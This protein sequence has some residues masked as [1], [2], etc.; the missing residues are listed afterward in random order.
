VGVVDPIGDPAVRD[1]RD[2]RQECQDI[3][4]FDAWAPVYE[5]SAL[6]EVFYARLHR[7]VLGLA[8]GAGSAPGRIVDVGCGTGRLLRT[9]A[10][11]FPDARLVGVDISA[12]MLAQAQ[13]M[14]APGERGV[15]VRADS[16]ALPFA[17]AAFDVATCTACSHHWPEP[18]AALGE[19]RRVVAADGLLVL[20]H[21]QGIALWDP[22]RA[23][24]IRRR[25]VRISSGLAVPLFDSG[26]RVSDAALFAECP[27]MP[28]TVVLCAR[29]R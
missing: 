2:V 1:L 14:T 11:A 29:R 12:G 10:G 27:L 6:Q 17:D 19:L 8:L 16:A 3:A 20:A 18:A 28:A 9:A 4:R 23:G 15:F 24:H 25:G 26:F 22:P 13:A 7:R 21:L 5:A